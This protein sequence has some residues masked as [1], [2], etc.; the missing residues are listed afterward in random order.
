MIKI[1]RLCVAGAILATL[2]TGLAAE[3]CQPNK[4]GA[5]DE[6]GAANLITPESVL[7]A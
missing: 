6:I 3:S 7:L 1:T 5:E 4:W 2:S